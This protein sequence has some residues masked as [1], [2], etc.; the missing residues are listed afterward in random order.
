MP[1]VFP[2]RSSSAHR[3]AVALT[4]LVGSMLARPALAATATPKPTPTATATPVLVRIVLKPTTAKRQVGQTQNFTA[5]GLYSDGLTT[6]NLTNREGVIFFSSDTSVVYPPNTKGNAGLVEAVGLGTAVVFAVDSAT[7]VNSNDTGD[8]ATMEVVAAPTPTPTNTGITP[9]RTK[10]PTPTA[11]AT[12]KL[13]TLEIAP[14]QTKR[15]VGQ[16]QNFSVKGTYSD[17]NTKNLT[18]AATYVSSNPSVVQCS[19]DTTTNK[20]TTLAVEPRRRDDLGVVRRPHD[21]GDR[22]RCGVHRRR[23]ADAD[24]DPHGRDADPHGEPD[25]HDDGDAGAGVD[26]ARAVNDQEGHRRLPE[27]HWSRDLLGR[28]HEELHPARDLRVEQ[29]VRRGR[30]ERPERRARAA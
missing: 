27:L 10:T 30:A 29:Y 21:D 5:T 3:L 24:R 1:T 11:T 22:R 7:G 4:L 8:S 2:A 18:Q 17:G 20:G 15:N 23:R 9:T 25:A 26:R 16:T 12:P 13:V 14:L 19:N 28:Q 6:A